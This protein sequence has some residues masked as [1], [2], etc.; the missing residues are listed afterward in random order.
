[1]V[2]FKFSKGKAKVLISTKA[3]EAGTVDPNAQMMTNEYREAKQRHD[4]QKSRNEQG[5]TSKA[6][7]MRPRITS[8]ILLH[9]WQWQQEKD[10]QRWFEEE[11]YRRHCKEERYEREQA[12]SHWNCPFLRHYWNEG[13]KLPTSN[14]CPERSDQY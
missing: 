3:K 14:N 6:G 5:E 11:S 2:E 12:E 7:A 10:Y 13:L 4:R 9:K 1:M 8:Q